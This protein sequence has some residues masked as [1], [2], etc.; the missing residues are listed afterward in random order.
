MKK[1]CE[2]R[3]KDIHGISQGLI[4][5]W[6]KPQLGTPVILK[7]IAFVVKSFADTKIRPQAFR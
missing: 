7:I 2:R 6:S 5:K 1:D 3:H 4:L